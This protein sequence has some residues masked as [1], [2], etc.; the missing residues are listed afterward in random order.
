MVELEMVELEIVELEAAEEEVELDDDVDDEVDECVELDEDEELLVDV[1]DG[2]GV[3]VLELVEDGVGVGV[4]VGEALEE[5]A[6]DEDA[7]F[8]LPELPISKTTISAVNPEGTVTTQKLAPP[9]PLAWSALVTPPIPSVDG[10][11]EHGSPL[12]PEPEHS[13]LIP[14]VGI[15]FDRELPVQ[16]G[17]Q[18]ILT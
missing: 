1:D 17:F 14:K 18:P 16:I 3:E 8:E 11:F 5:A 9:A 13:T 4:G 12:H 15:V 2:G 7:G 10:S 6:F